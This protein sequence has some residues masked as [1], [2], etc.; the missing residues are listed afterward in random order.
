M[1]L[2]V[3]IVLFVAGCGNEN[4]TPTESAGLKTVGREQYVLQ[5]KKWE[6]EMHKSLELN[7][8]TASQAIKAYTDFVNAFPA[9][10]LAPDF[11]FKSG[12]IAT[13]TKQYPQALMFYETI[14]SKYPKYK[15]VDVSLY[16]QGVLLDNYLNDDAKAKVIYEQV[17]AKYPESSYARDARAAIGNLGKSDEELIKEFEKKNGVK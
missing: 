16:L 15:L 12:E 9:D 10:S 11:L 2:V 4:K 8:V 7:T 5:I 3:G 13:A 1:F 17:I 6:A 14:T